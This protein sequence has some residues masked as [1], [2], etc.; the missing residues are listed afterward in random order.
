MSLFTYKEIDKAYYQEQIRDFLP[1][2]IIDAHTH[3]YSTRFRHPPKAGVPD[4]S[5]NWPNLV[6]EDNPI[7]DLLET[8]RIMM[9]EQEVTPVIFG[10]P[11][12]DYDVDA[13]NAY[14]AECAKKYD[15]PALYLA[16]PWES[17]AEIEERIRDGGFGGI[18]VYLNFAPPYIPADEI[19]IFDFL[20]HWQLEVMNHHKWIV[21]LHIPRS[22]RLKDPVN[23]EQMLEIDRRYPD[24]KLIIAHVG[25]AY[26]PEDLGDALDRLADTGMWF[27]FA[28][29]TNQFVF[30]QA[31]Q[32]IG[33]KRLMFGTDL[34]ILRMRMRRIVENGHYIN[35]V[36]RGM[37]GD[38][39]GDTHMREVDDETASKLSIFLY[40]EIAAIRGAAEGT[41]LGKADIEQLFYHTAAE[42]FSI[43]I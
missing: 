31:I 4:R 40:E 24:V 41:Q 43:S 39:S 6:A 35:L 14:I 5:Q 15:F 1:K 29:N 2:K 22:G 16:R 8:Y 9:P 42:L 19:R 33:P 36:P 27:D 28:A 7:E 17:A 11:S 37:Y 3:V 18:K 26:A 23:L 13:N 20:P 10:Q 25:R 12:L 32:K 30:E 34:P 21:M 38:V